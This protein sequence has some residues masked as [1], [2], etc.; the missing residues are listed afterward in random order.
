MGLV[1]AL[2]GGLRRFGVDLIRTRNLAKLRADARSAG[3][4]AFLCALDDA[5][6][7]PALDCLPHSQG[8]LRQDIFALASNGFKRNGF[9]VEFGAT[10]GK[11]LSNSWLLEKHFGWTGILAEPGRVW[12]PRL[13]ANRTARIEFDCVWSR[14]GEEFSFTEADEA[15]LSTISSFSE[16]DG[17]AASR[18]SSRSYTVKTVAFNELLERH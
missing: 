12:H 8:Q 14:T 17:H 10:D 4:I 13:T 18:K 6:L 1:S 15:E 3:D 9:F 11:T 16:S 2:R 7:R 5:S